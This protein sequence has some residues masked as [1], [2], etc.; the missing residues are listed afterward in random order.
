MDARQYFLVTMKEPNKDVLEGIVAVFWGHRVA[1]YRNEEGDVAVE[2]RARN[3]DARWSESEKSGVRSSNDFPDAAG[4]PEIM[5]LQTS[6][7]A[8]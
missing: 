4:L 3:P 8:G 1:A 7:S 2:W 5:G 6:F